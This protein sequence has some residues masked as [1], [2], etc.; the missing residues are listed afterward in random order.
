MARSPANVHAAS[1]AEFAE[2]R[3]RVRAE[4]ARRSLAA[5]VVSDPANLFYLT[6]YDAW[7]FY[8][9]QCLIVPSDGPVVLYARAMDAAG[10][11][12]TCDLPAENVVGYPEA[13]VHR[14]DV[15][16]F[17]W[18]TASA[19]ERGLLPTT[20]DAQIAAECDAHYFSARAYTALVAGVGDATVVDSGEL[21]NWVR[22]VKSE[23]EIAA[24]RIAG[25]IADTAMRGALEAVSPGRRQCDVAADIV[26][27]QIRGTLEHGGD[28]TAIPPML[29]TGAAAGVPH[30]TWSE[31]PFVTGEATT[32]E[33]AGA[34][35]R[36]HA[37]LARTIHLGTAPARLVDTSKAV[38]EALTVAL[39]ELRPGAVVADVHRATN[40]VLA[41]WGLVK[42]SRM[43][44]SIGIGY[45]PDW[46]ERTVSLRAEDPTVIRAGMAFHVIL[47]IWMDGWGYEAS[48]PVVIT[49]V[50]AERLAQLPPELTVRT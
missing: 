5:L 25:T 28:H 22:L 38:D 26:A 6:G 36:Y 19:R 3:R 17:D 4:M 9:P 15:H 7:S 35:N 20:A 44:Y 11:H 31:A 49:A 33:L 30:L 45:P 24:L 18:I 46:G 42:D 47:G 10:A 21:V 8:T 1:A 23:H 39:S 41:R 48:E 14:P 2:R 16:P 40:D 32:I 27:L 43:G 50:G 13:L 37:P 34:F 12:H 29:P